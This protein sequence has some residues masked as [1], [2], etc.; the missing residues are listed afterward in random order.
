MGGG[1]VMDMELEH[2]KE[3]ARRTARNAARE[4]GMEGEMVWAPAGQGRLSLEIRAV[5]RSAQVLVLNEEQLRQATYDF[6]AQ[7]CLGSEIRS[8]IKE[9]HER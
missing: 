6:D 1:F 2:G 4:L 9:V 7:Y 5:E 3:W 8:A